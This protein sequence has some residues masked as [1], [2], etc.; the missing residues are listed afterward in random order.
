MNDRM[1]GFLR[2]AP[3][4]ILAGALASSP[5]MAGDVTGRPEFGPSAAPDRPSYTPGSVEC[6]IFGTWT[7]YSDGTSNWKIVVT[8][9]LSI[10]ERGETQ[11]RIHG[12]KKIY[13]ED[14]PDDKIVFFGMPKGC[15]DDCAFISVIRV[16]WSSGSIP[17]DIDYSFVPERFHAECLLVAEGY[18]GVRQGYVDESRWNGQVTFMRPR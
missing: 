18:K 3:L 16:T 1:T 13:F 7:G 15:T 10:D 9:E 14:W 17:S 12:L 11:Y 8:P 5:A 6:E 4:A 2:L